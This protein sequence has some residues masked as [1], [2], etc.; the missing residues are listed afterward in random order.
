MNAITASPSLFFRFVTYLWRWLLFGAL[1]GLVTPVIGPLAN[2]AMPDGYFWHL[3]LEQL[4]FG[5]FFGLVCAVVFTL[6]QNTLNKGRRRG[7]SWAILIFTWLAT[8]MCILRRGSGCSRLTV[9]SSGR[10]R[11]R[12][13]QALART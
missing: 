9:H 7:V 11:R 5:L 2:G 8:K 6:L 13:I 3:K 4:G 1:G 10:L 12:L